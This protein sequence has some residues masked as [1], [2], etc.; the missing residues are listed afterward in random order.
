[1]VSLYLVGGIKSEILGPTLSNYIF[2]KEIE[3]IQYIKGLSNLPINSKVGKYKFISTIFSEIDPMYTRDT[4]FY[5]FL[6]IFNYQDSD[7]DKYLQLAH[8]S[9]KI[10]KRIT[11]QYLSILKDLSK[12]KNLSYTE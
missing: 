5:Y 6:L 3:M 4:C 1:M 7:N 11:N 12:K 10:R 8:L 2:Y 9:E